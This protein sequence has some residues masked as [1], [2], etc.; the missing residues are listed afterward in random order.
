MKLRIVLVLLWCAGLFVCI[1]TANFSL[2]LRQH[3]V[4]FEWHSHPKMSDLLLLSDF[5]Y[6]ERPTFLIQKIGHF[7]GFFGLT[8]L[9]ATGV[10]TPRAFWRGVALAAGYAV[11]TELLQPFFGRDGRIFDMFIDGAGITL[12]AFIAHRVSKKR[13]YT[14]RRHRPYPVSRAARQ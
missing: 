5:R 4:H 13:W 14:A 3:M 2:L 10:R 11:L 8:L 9:A 12:A 1:N 7:S 6:Y